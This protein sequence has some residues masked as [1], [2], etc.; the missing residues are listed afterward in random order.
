MQDGE[1]EIPIYFGVKS[2]KVKATTELCQD[3]GSDTITWVVF[4]VQLSYFMKD[5]ERIVLYIL[6]SVG[7][8]LR[9]SP[10]KQMS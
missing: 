9:L 8:S 6:I 5:D 1:R 10:E 4:N 3:F 2:T 7:Q